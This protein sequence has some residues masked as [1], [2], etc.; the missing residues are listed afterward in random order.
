MIKYIRI[1]LFLSGG[2]NIHFINDTED[3]HSFIRTSDIIYFI[4]IGTG[5]QLTDRLSIAICFHQ[6]LN[7][8][9]GYTYG[10]FPG[11]ASG[12]SEIP[13]MLKLGIAAIL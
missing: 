8:K 11:D 9:F 10:S 7:K 4:F 2:I 3:G 12:P 6:A 5:Y 13:N 1:D